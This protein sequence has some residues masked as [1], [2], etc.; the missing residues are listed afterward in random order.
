MFFP[1]TLREYV[2][3]P[4]GKGSMAITGKRLILDDLDRRF[5]KIKKDIV[6]KMYNDKKNFFFHFIIPS[7]SERNNTYDVV[8]EFCDDENKLGYDNFL[9]KY[10]LRFFSNCPSF[11]YTYGFVYN[12]ND[13]MINCLKN[14]YESIVLTDNPLF[15]NRQ[16]II[17]YE[18]SIYFACKYILSDGRLQNKSYINVVGKHIT[19][20]NLAKLIRNTATIK[21]EIDKENNRLSTEAKKKKQE[22]TKVK[23][24]PSD[25][26][27]IAKST[28]TSG[29][30]KK[31]GS[32]RITPKKKITPVKRTYKK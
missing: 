17:N 19:H 8:I 26:N 13:L 30:P 14:K 31:T 32:N 7:E 12:D 1:Q 4:M 9:Y 18:K 15:R 2:E 29:T 27:P 28:P 21:L 6:C 10:T 22:T 11:T 23:R 3:N 16:E 25:K 24:T 20:E 5:N